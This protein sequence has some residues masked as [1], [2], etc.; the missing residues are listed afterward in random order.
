M[1]NREYE[2]RRAARQQAEQ[3]FRTPAGFLKRI[4]FD[5]LEED[6]AEFCNMLGIVGRY[7]TWGNDR[8]IADTWYAMVIKVAD[9]RVE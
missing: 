1:T 5:G 6:K 8:A 7:A 9:E 2:V 3:F 4:N